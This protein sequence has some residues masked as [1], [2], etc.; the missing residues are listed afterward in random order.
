[1]KVIRWLLFLP[2]IVGLLLLVRPDDAI[3]LSFVQRAEELRA[4]IDFQAA[5]D[6]LRVA[7]QRQP[8]NAT[9]YLRLSFILALQHKNTEAAQALAE[10]E[11]LGADVADVETLRAQW[12]QQDQRYADA[13]QH[14]QHVIEQLPLD[15]SA[16]FHAVETAVQAE[17]WDLARSTAERW[18]AALNSEEAHLT[19]GKLLAFDDPAAAQAHLQLSID[20]LADS[21]LQALQQPDRALQ[22]MLL[23][24]AYLAQNDLGQDYLALA[25]RAF[26][27]AAAI[28]PEYAEAQA[29]AGFVRDQR[30]AD[31]GAWLD[32]AVELDPNLT[33]ARYFRAR[34]RWDRSDLDGALADLN[35][36]IER[37]PAN[38]LIAAEIGRVYTQRSDFANAEQWLIRARDLRP[39]DA[40]IWKSLAELYA[41]RAYGTPDQAVATAQQIV[42]LAPQDAEAHL[43]LGRAYLRSGDRNGAEHELT[44]AARLD[45]NSALVRFYLGRLYGGD[46]E[47]GRLEYLRALTLDPAGPIGLAAQRVLE[48]P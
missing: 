5:A 36:A 33:V 38:A 44:E 11:R 34:H 48:L 46:T 24:R 19:L 37:A 32:R 6:Y 16:Y 29:F 7:L 22:L 47:A 21:F 14:W 40:E 30:G 1:M 27:T 8:W 4:S 35:H 10:A 26:D 2:L 3:T 23:G 45:P 41:G 12:A 42:S 20:V 43:W 13:A 31:G 28:N 18:V 9:L 39:Q 17:Q 25:Q 15:E